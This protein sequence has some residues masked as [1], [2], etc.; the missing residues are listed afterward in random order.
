[1]SRAKLTAEPTPKPSK[2]APPPDDLYQLLQVP[3]AADQGTIK[4]AYYKMQKICHPDVAGPEGEEMC[5]LLN[6]AYDVLSDTT[7]RTAYDEQLHRS[8][9]SAIEKVEVAT[10]L[11][12]TWQWQP[13]KHG[14][15]PIWRGAPRSRSR[16][17][18]VK[19]QDRGEKHQDQ[20][21]VYVDE[22]QCISCRNCCDIAPQSFCIDAE[23]GRA[24]VY[25]QWGNSE[26]YLDYAVAACP[27]D[28]IYWVSREELQALEHVTAEKMFDLAGSLPCS[29]SVMNGMFVGNL[30]D[31]FHLAQRFVKRQEEQKRRQEVLGMERVAPDRFRER[32]LGVFEKLSEALR[33]A[34]LG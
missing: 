31:P 13:K 15:A 29:M 26:E 8:K 32:I 16:W 7:T 10:D 19:P 1:M 28:C 30:E 24:R 18:R 20:K 33:R 6:D 3:A 22:W 17:D 27:V 11:G 21:F 12:P 14:S 2:K 9:S 25:T 5:I 23:H 4:R 34:V